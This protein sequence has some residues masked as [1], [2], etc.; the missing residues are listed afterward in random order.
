MVIGVSTRS[1]VLLQIPLLRSIYE[2]EYEYCYL[3]GS[4]TSQDKTSLFRLYTPQAK[5]PK[6]KHWLTQKISLVPQYTVRCA[7]FWVTV[8]VLR[9]SYYVQFYC[10]AAR[11]RICDDDDDDRISHITHHRRFRLVLYI[12]SNFSILSYRYRYR[13]PYRKVF[14]IR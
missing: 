10:C 5:K 6:E 12:V 1:R 8:R 2:Y 11:T 13:K 14:D 7:R 3:P 4:F 9:H